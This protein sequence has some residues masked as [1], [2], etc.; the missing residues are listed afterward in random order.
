MT[1]HGSVPFQWEVTN[2]DTAYKSFDYLLTYEGTKVRT[3]AFHRFIKGQ[4]E[5]GDPMQSPSGGTMLAVIAP[6]ASVSFTIDINKLYELTQSGTYTLL[7]SHRDDSTGSV[8]RSEPIHV[9]IES[10]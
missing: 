4:S 7:A 8:I 6:G 1:N 10:E 5:P 9:V 2:P 3:T